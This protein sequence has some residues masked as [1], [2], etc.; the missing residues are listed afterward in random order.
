M[1]GTTIAGRVLGALRVGGIVLA[2]SPLF[3]QRIAS[4]GA[5]DRAGITA[6]AQMPRFA[7][8][9][10]PL[11]TTPNAGGAGA[12]T[13]SPSRIREIV[14][15]LASDELAGRR[16]GTAENRQAAKFIAEAFAKAGLRPIPGSTSYEQTFDYAVG[17]EIG[18]GNLFSMVVGRPELTLVAETVGREFN[19]AGFSE[20]GKVKG[21]LLFAGYGITAPKL[22]YDDYAGVDA[23][24]KIVLLMRYSPDGGNPHGDFGHYAEMSAKVANARE[25]GAAGI[26][27]INQPQDS[28]E[29]PRVQL[30]RNFGNVGL[31]TIFALSTIFDRLR[32]PA[33]RTLAQVQGRIDSTR[34]PA[35]FAPAGWSANVGTDVKTR[36]EQ[37]PNVLGFLPGSDPKL[38]DEWI[39]VGGHFDHLGWGGEGS[40][41][42]GKD[43]AIHHGADDN[44]SGTAGVI[45]LAERFGARGGNRHPI[46]FV[47]FNG[48]EEG[49]LGSAS[50]LK[51]GVIPAENVAAMINMDMIGRLDSNHLIVEGIGTSPLWDSLVPA[52]NHDRL[53][54]KLGKSGYGPSD[55]ASFYAK[56]IPVLFLFTGTH[57]DYHRPSDTWEKV[58]Y[59]GEARVVG[60]V[61]DLVQAID[62]RPERPPFTKV[63][64]SSAERANMGFKVYVGTIP[65]YAYEGKG[66]R[67]SG[68]SEGGPAQKAGL[69][70]GD[71]IM[72]LASKEINNIYDYT[73]VLGELKP[74]QTVE[75]EF[76]RG[77]KTMKVNVL[78]GSR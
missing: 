68:V 62:A 45:A 73:Y 16:T 13:I 27:I 47:A 17:V 7:P 61:N 1:I 29:L 30:E 26:I 49:L 14:R 63:T 37:V 76:L 50:L 22:G 71:I 67:L 28:A 58:N 32:D 18:G 20:S 6:R 11:Q 40:L 66:L 39:V 48:E 8:G 3:A 23:H 75:V 35:S 51:D 72:K 33:G 31:P 15:Y 59:D 57:R 4:M 25:H 60:L 44:A 54:L 24:G 5:A 78:L 46:L 42:A 52:V 34:R 69:T 38:R 21:D 56:N 19:P 55:H 10:A 77:G 74:K 2:I 36:R 12:D 41:Y 70:E 43:S 9:N 53:T 65:D 64:E